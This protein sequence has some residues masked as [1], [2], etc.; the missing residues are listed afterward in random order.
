MTTNPAIGPLVC[1]YGLAGGTF[2]DFANKRNIGTI[3]KNW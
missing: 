2:E 3:H 1:R